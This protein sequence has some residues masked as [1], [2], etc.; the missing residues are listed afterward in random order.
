MPLF[1]SMETTEEKYNNA[2][3]LIFSHETLFFNA[4]AIVISAFLPAIN[5]NPRA[6]LVNI[7]T[8]EGAAGRMA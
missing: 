4:G 8:S 2:I 7:C 1:I 6:T 3:W 5:K